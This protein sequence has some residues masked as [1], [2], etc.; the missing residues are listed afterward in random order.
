LLDA[1]IHTKDTEDTEETKPSCPLWW[2]SATRI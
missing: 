2:I 1:P